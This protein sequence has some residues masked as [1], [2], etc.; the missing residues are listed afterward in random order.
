MKFIMDAD[1]LIKLTKAHLKELVCRSF[2]IVLPEQVK[3]EVV[4]AGSD[5]PDA[6]VIQENIRRKIVSVEPEARKKHGKGEEGALALFRQ[7]EY[8]AIC[9]DD[10]KFVRRLRIMEVPYVTPAILVLLLV[11]HR[12]L[13]VSQALK[14]L[15]AL[16][17]FVSADEYAVARLKLESMRGGRDLHED[18]IAEIT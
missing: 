13:P 4:D 9:T 17:P 14:R 12:A 16:A 7:S 18:E 10:R 11:K 2:N 1:C 15:E 6:A 3:R 8:D 5:H